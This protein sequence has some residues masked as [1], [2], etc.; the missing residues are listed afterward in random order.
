MTPSDE[1]NV[2]VLAR[3]TATSS[4]DLLLFP[5]DLTE[6]ET[7]AKQRSQGAIPKRRPVVHDESKSPEGQS[8]SRKRC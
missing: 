2:F 5:V 6:E 1:A 4:I 7:L 3:V 8:M